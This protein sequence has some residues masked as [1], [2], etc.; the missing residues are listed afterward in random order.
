MAEAVGVSALP[1][2]PTDYELEH[3]LAIVMYGGVSLAIYIGGIARELLGVIRA[4]SPSRNNPA[5]AGLAFD[6]LSPSEKIYRR[7]AQ[8]TDGISYDATDG[9]KLPI[10][11]RVSID[12]VSGTSA[13]GINGI[14]LA[15]ALANDTPLD[16]ILNLWIEEGD[17]GKL[18]ND[19]ESV[20]DTKG[21]VEQVPPVALLNGERMY[22]K[23]LDAFDSMD[24]ETSG[25][26]YDPGRVDLFVTTTDIRGEV[27]NLPVDNTVAQER[28]HRQRFHFTHDGGHSDELSNSENP[29]LAYAARCT[30]SFPFAFEPFTWADAARL[31]GPQRAP[32]AKWN[33]RLMFTSPNYESRP[34][35]D[36]GYLDNKP[37]SYAIDELARRQSGLDVRRALIY[38]E[39]DPETIDPSVAK[40]EQETK[41]D[42][43]DNALAALI[44]IP[45]YETIREDLQRVVERNARVDDFRD[46]EKKVDAGLDTWMALPRRERVQ[47]GKAKTNDTPV[48]DLIERYGPGYAAYH[49]VKVASVIDM[50]A[51]LICVSGSI[52]RPEIAQVIRDL[53]REWV[54]TAYSTEVQQMEL[55]LDADIDYRLRKLSFLIRKATPPKTAP[56]PSERV[57]AARASLKKTYDKIYVIRGE[58]RDALQNWVRGL[59]TQEA[60]K[61][62]A[63][64]A[65]RKKD[66]RRDAIQ[67]MVASLRKEGDHLKTILSTV[68][69]EPLISAAKE[70]DDAL[71]GEAADITR[72]RRYYEQFENYDM[73]IFPMAQKGG[74]DEGVDVDIVRVSPRD[75]R[76]PHKLQGSQLGHFGGFLEDDWRRND[77]LWGRLDAAE[78]IICRMLP[79][80]DQCQRYAI[81]EEAQRAIIAEQLGSDLRKRLT[82]A[83]APKPGAF[84]LSSAAA[85]RR[86]LT[87]EAAAKGCIGDDRLLHDLFVGGGGYD[88]DMNRDVQIVSAGRAGVIVEKILKGS[89]E[90]AHWPWPAF[91]KMFAAAF[92]MLAQVAVPRSFPRVI[93]AY[94]GRL[95]AVLFLA[96]IAVGIVTNEK[97]PLL[98]GIRGVAVIAV[99][100]F[101]TFLLDR[102]IHG[103]L[104]KGILFALLTIAVVAV[105]AWYVNAKAWISF[106]RTIII[107]KPI[108]YFFLGFAIGI[109]LIEVLIR[110]WSWL[111]AAW[112]RKTLKARGVQ[113]PAV[114]PTTP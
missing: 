38:V 74:I 109:V 36:G 71:A 39:P 2:T 25:G 108:E 81:V 18:L 16:A 105:G 9:V 51:D 43:I 5:Q 56:P 42:A 85:R 96:L 93:G 82:E 78:A 26:R 63:D 6:A 46:V 75:V 91:P 110:G 4:T 68:T 111:I 27:I 97:A 44:S 22:R 11:K 94:W 103:K 55:L 73:V 65:V 100:L 60:E 49:Q 20:K 113:Q 52:A 104:V 72:L 90:K 3:R 69:R 28:R 62:L 41:P 14:F 66:D 77:I 87:I 31:A 57:K 21:L 67:Q 99:A 15:K 80:M 86:Q 102:W 45:G 32:Q 7:I 19:G 17:L 37:F 79:D 98:I 76:N 34:M 59:L 8:M 35:G 107:P 47:D 10:K 58:L 92:A 83:S 88:S 40:K 48:T 95:L 106:A 54:R 84:P 12:I 1:P 89:A 33:E 61:S 50:L 101:V 24:T 29:T 70:A 23:L 114:N 30:S 13:G 112:H 53:V 64:I